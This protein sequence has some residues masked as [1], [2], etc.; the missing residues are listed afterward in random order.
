VRVYNSVIEENFAVIGG[1]AYVNN[2]GFVE[3]SSSTRIVKNAAINTCF[4]FLI[5]TQDFSLLSSVFVSQNDQKHNFI[6][7]EEFLALEGDFMHIKQAY[8]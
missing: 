4:L 6:K 8:I 1:V 7:K 5:N 3:F 2:D